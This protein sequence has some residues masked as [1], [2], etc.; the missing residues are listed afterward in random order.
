MCSETPQVL[1]AVPSFSGLPR[2]PAQFP[3]RR[4]L[5]SSPGLLP[6]LPLP[7]GGQG[8]QQR[9]TQEER[10]PHVGALAGLACWDTLLGPGTLSSASGAG[11]GSLAAWPWP[12]VSVDTPPEF[13]S[14]GGEETCS[15]NA[16]SQA[17]EG[18]SRDPQA[19]GD[20]PP[21]H[22]ALSPSVSTRSPWGKA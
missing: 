2:A 4:H 17:Q 18:G 21:G 20:M 11:E 13:D 12:G 19:T 8:G 22:P 6:F 7:F 15:G 5:P 14:Y 9:H 1:G 16:R 3:P 10:W